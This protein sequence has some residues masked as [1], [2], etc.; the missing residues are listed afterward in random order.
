MSDKPI[1]ANEPDV[2]RLISQVVQLQVE[3]KGS[4]ELLS[5]IKEW[6]HFGGSSGWTINSLKTL[7]AKFLREVKK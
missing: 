7:I 1:T 5:E 2:Q 6:C 3:V 4:K